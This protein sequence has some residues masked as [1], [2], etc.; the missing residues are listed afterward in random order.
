MYNSGGVASKDESNVLCCIRANL[1]YSNKYWSIWESQQQYFTEVISTYY[2]VPSPLH[3]MCSDENNGNF[4]RQSSEIKTQNQVWFIVNTSILRVIIY[5][6]I[7]W[8]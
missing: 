8:Q 4:Y 1:K 6:D 2:I 3:D 7:L 5:I